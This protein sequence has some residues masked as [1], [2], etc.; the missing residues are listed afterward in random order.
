[1]ISIQKEKHNGKKKR[2]EFVLFVFLFFFC[3][4]IT[5]NK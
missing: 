2:Q 1:M 4:N 5:Q 3:L